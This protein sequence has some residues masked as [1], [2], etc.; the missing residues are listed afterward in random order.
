MSGG[1]IIQSI[2][3]GFLFVSFLSCRIYFQVYTVIFSGLSFFWL[4]MFESKNTTIAYKIVLVT[5]A[6]GVLVNVLLN[7]YWAYLI[8]HQ[9]YRILTRGASKVETGFNPQHDQNPEVIELKQQNDK[10]LDPE[11]PKSDN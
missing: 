4:K 2:N 10:I 5:M 1:N 8:V 7:F 11:A 3:S 9:V 6:L